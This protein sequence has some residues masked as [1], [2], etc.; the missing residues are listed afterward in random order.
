MRVSA[1]VVLLALAGCVSAEDTN[2]WRG[3]PVAELDRHPIFNAMHMTRRVT[4]DGTEIRDYQ[5]S[6]WLPSAEVHARWPPLGPIQ[7]H[8]IIVNVGPIAKSL[9]TI[10]TNPCPPSSRWGCRPRQIALWRSNRG[11]VHKSK[12]YTDRKRVA[13]WEL[14]AQRP[15]PVQVT[16]GHQDRR[17]APRAYGTRLRRVPIE[18]PVLSSSLLCHFCR[19]ARLNDINIGPIA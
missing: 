9:R 2:A 4:A 17:R 7:S 10:R 1:A 12:R 13:G 16:A 19:N 11:R 8:T 18:G 5:N 3:R 15:G 14:V 6:K